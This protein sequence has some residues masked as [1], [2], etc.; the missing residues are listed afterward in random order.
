MFCGLFR[1][2][3]NSFLIINY[4][5]LLFQQ[6]INMWKEENKNN[7]NEEFKYANIGN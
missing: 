4:I 2:F 3:M 6:T 7:H 5:N 1:S